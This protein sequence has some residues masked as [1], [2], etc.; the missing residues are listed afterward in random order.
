V[1]DTKI[2]PSHWLEEGADLSE[3][4]LR[5]WMQDISKDLKAAIAA[6]AVHSQESA[7]YRASNDARVK[8]LEDHVE[9]RSA[10]KSGLTM[11]GIGALFGVIG[12]YLAKKL[13][14]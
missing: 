5:E 6:Q 12:S 1:G 8:N 14:I 7:V 13:G 11:S 4:E 10:L 9:R 2:L 3:H